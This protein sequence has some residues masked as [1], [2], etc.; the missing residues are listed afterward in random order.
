MTAGTALIDLGEMPRERP[1]ASPADDEPAWP[2]GQRRLL[3]AI[4]SIV[5]IALSAT[6]PVAPPLV[7][8][9]LTTEG[10]DLVLYG[11]DR[12]YAFGLGE[13]A[14]D[15]TVTAYGLPDGA[16]RWRSQVP[17]QWVG[18]L[19]VPVAGPP[20]VISDETAVRGGPDAPSADAAVVAASGRVLYR[21]GAQLIGMIPH[22]GVMLWTSRSGV[23]GVEA[24]G[25]HL[26]G[27]D[28][29]TEAVRWTYDAPTGAWLWWD[30]ND[31]GLRS[32]AVMLA[33]GRLEL[34]DLERGALLATAEG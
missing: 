26:V 28:P 24:G 30:P 21:T 14:G 15:R 16:V 4:V 2:P 9:G 25:R 23:F 32:A 17:S 22:G 27:R 1:A 13:G 29:D 8:S 12:Y 19:T 10:R 3:G 7:A 31:G 11:P 5:L 20:T 6:V 34:R 33:S 18:W